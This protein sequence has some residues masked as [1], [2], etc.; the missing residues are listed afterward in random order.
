[1]TSNEEE[2][3]SSLKSV[4]DYLKSDPS[5]RDETTPVAQLEQ[6]SEPLTFK[7]FFQV[8]SLVFALFIFVE[9]SYTSS[10]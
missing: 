9:F 7:G 6:G 8:R 3:I 1:M 5:N 2:R 10:N 4:S